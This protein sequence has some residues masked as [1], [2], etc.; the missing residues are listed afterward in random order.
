VHI[1]HG[2]GTGTLRMETMHMIEGIPEKVSIFP[3]NNDG[4]VTVYFKY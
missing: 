1:I 2:R 3:T 4:G